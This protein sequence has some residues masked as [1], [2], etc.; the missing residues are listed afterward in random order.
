MQTAMKCKK[1]E[2][3]CNDM[4]GITRMA[5]QGGKPVLQLQEC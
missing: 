1:G 4:D 2:I 5:L 3:L